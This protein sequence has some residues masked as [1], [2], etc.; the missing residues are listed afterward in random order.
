MKF[1]EDIISQRNKAGQMVCGDICL[2]ERRIEG[3]IFLVCD[4]VGSGVYAN[5]AAI[6]CSERI[7]ELIRSGTSAR[8]ATEMVA[9]SMHRARTENIPFSAFSLCIILPDGTFTIYTYESPNAI[10]Y[11]NGS[12]GVLAPRY[13][14][15]GFEMIGEATG[16]MR[17]GDALLLF[18]D[19]VSQAGLGHGH[20]L[21]IGS[22]G[23]ASFINRLQKNQSI[24]FLPEVITSMVTDLSDGK[25]EDDVSLGMLYC[26]EAVHFSIM[27]GPPAKPSRDKS[28]VEEFINLPGQK[29]ICGSTTSEIVSRVLETPIRMIVQGDSIG[30]MPEYHIEGVDITTEG[31]IVLNQVYNLLDEPI[32]KLMDN[33][34]SERLCLMLKEADVI[35]LMIG[36]A[37]NK[38]HESVLFKQ[39]GVRVRR[40][41]IELISNKLKAMGKLVI[42]VYH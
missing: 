37:V 40:S 29:A 30:K 33:S 3:T 20:G 28:F 25:A 27:S 38:A 8:V 15:A 7:M 42:E 13:Y 31:A 36:N 18:S 16:V 11:Q 41:T 17:E 21:G 32:D 12:A 1:F 34:V 2:C 14:T 10:L 4:G 22:D 9:S 23:V 35:H 5:I 19:G 26:R 39:I 6:V 24:R